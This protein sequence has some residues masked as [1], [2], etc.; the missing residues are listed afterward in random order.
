MQQHFPAG[1]SGLSK[2]S[3]RAPGL[4]A[5]LVYGQDLAQL[6]GSIPDRK[7][8]AQPAKAAGGQAFREAEVLVLQ[9]HH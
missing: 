3:N 1:F 5:N 7:P 6:V 9:Q 8:A 2:H 4:P